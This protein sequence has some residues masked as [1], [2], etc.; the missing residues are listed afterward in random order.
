MMK[1]SKV[2]MRAE[3]EYSHDIFFHVGEAGRVYLCISA[4]QVVITMPRGDAA[5]AKTFRDI[6]DRYAATC[7]AKPE[8]SEAM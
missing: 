7:P 6:A 3:I 2:E 5:F 8:I 4:Q 1:V